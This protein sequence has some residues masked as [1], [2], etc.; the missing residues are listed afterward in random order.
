MEYKDK[1]INE[2]QL[3]YL[4]F[5]IPTCILNDEGMSL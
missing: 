2:I 5:R 4:S 3:S 1:P